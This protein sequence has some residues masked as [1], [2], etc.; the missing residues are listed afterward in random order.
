MVAILTDM[1]RVQRRRN[2][3]TEGATP[4]QIRVDQTPIKENGFI[5]FELG[6]N[7][8]PANRIIR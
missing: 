7:G 3:N 8:A 4:V 6:I 2:T 1:E 5:K